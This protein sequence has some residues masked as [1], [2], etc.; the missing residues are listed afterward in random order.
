MY[1]EKITGKQVCDDLHF[2]FLLNIL[3]IFF[4]EVT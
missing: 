2:F 1:P 3:N 4:V